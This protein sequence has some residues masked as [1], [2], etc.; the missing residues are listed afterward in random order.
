MVVIKDCRSWGQGFYVRSTSS[1]SC[2]SR[3]LVECD[4]VTLTTGSFW[5]HRLPRNV[6]AVFFI[7]LKKTRAW[8]MWIPWQTVICKAL[9]GFTGFIFKS[10]FLILNVLY[11]YYFLYLQ[12]IN[13]NFTKYI[14]YYY[15]LFTFI[16]C[17]SEIKLS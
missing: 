2:K 8:R 11:L 10:P 9:Y 16:C 1:P 3:L 15:Y 6:L 4:M 12:L 17:Q 14:Y 5:F 13:L 7:L